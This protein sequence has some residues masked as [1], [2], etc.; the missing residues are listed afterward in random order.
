V[1]TLEC[2]REPEVVAAVFSGTVLA[3]TVF[4]ERGGDGVGEEG[5]GLQM[6]I[7]TCEICRDVV[8][9]ASRLRDDRDAA[10]WDVQVPA[11]GQIWWRAAI[12]ARL[13]AAHAA[14][15]PLTWAHGI[16][17]ACAAGLAAGA[18]SVA[19]PTIV[20]AF[21]WFGDRAWSVNPGTVAVADLAAAMMQRTFPF[22][23]VAACLLLAPLALY[24]ALSDE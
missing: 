21:S 9:V 15:R 2:P 8:T 4:A 5:E 23:L 16:A 18:L 24:F 12:R 22:A 17:G 13:E 20:R 10:L 6:H 11:A 7:E 1:K 14:A 19:W 3:G